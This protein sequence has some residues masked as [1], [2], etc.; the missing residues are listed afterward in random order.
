MKDWSFLRMKKK[1][2]YWGIKLLLVLLLVFVVSPKGTQTIEAIHSHVKSLGK[3]K[4][5]GEVVETTGN[6][7]K[8]AAENWGLSFQE[9]GKPPVADV[10]MAELEPYNA[11][12]MEDTQEKVIYLTFDAGYENGYTP[13]ILEALKKHNVPATFFLVGHYLE[14]NQELVKQMVAEG[15]V[16]GNHSYHHPDMS[17]MGQQE[18]QK[19]LQQLE[20]L[21]KEITGQEMEKFY[22]PPQGKYSME[23]LEM[24]KQAGYKTIFWS[25]AYMDW[26]VDKQPSHEDAMAKLTQ[27]I[28]P[29]AIVLL[30]STSQT[31]AEIMDEILT[32][33]KEMGY[34]FKSLKDL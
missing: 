27:R 32:K 24:A 15:H 26:D 16:V 2:S 20:V 31:N 12:Y 8:N 6:I 5:H 19:E 34:T 11:W 30:H 10:S 17:K 1:K 33:W 21:Y 3:T 18:F 23:N 9:E 25:L 29:G 22:R 28:H 13:K 14:T 4:E 7:I